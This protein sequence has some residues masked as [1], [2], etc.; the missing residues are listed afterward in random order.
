MAEEYIPVENIKLKEPDLKAKNNKTWGE[1][2][3]EKKIDREELKGQFI[4]ANRVGKMH[5][6]QPGIMKMRSCGEMLLW[7]ILWAKTW[8]LVPLV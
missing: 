8:P 3:L 6:L 5:R 1:V 7:G 4:E 2:T